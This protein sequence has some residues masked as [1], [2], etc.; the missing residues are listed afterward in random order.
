MAS[1]AGFLMF[2]SVPGGRE[3]L[4]IANILGLI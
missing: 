3:K 2:M 1:K 4:D